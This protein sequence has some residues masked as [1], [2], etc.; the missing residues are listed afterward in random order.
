MTG[1]IIAFDKHWNLVLRDVD[2]VYLKPK[3]SKTP[4]LREILSSDTFEEM[5]AK[6][7][8]EKKDPPPEPPQPKEGAEKKKKRR[9]KAKSTSAKRH[10]D[11]LFIRGDNIVM[12]CPLDE[13]QS[14]DEE[15]EEEQEE[16]QTKAQCCSCITFSS[17]LFFLVLDF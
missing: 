15:E 3:K 16:G 13:T 8:R 7:P 5:P 14:A 1:Y 4:F 10:V 2:E 6:T 12:V 9:K 11:K 17:V